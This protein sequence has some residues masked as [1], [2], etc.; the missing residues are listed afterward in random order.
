MN[1]VNWR[2][3]AEVWCE[4]ETGIKRNQKAP[5]IFVALPDRALEH[6]KHIPREVL[7]SKEGVKTLLDKLAELYIPDKLGDRIKQKIQL[8]NK[9]RKPGE[10]V[11]KHIEEYMKIFREYRM[12]CTHEYDDTD[13]AIEIMASCDL[14]EADT[15]TV[16]AQMEEP[17]SSANVIQILKRIFS[18]T[19]QEKYNKDKN[20]S[21]IFLDKAAEKRYTHHLL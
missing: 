16:S 17:P 15:K 9:R 2:I 3:K 20:D 8:Y 21:D 6:T 11:I 4:T 14:T 1:F 19:N 12:L 5:K 18:M 10:C 7:R 13:L